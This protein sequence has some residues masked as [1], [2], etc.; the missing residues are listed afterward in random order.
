MKIYTKT[1]DDGS[2]SLGFGKRIPKCD[3]NIQSL[4]DLD[5]LNSNIGFLLSLIK[6]DSPQ[7]NNESFVNFLKKTQNIIFDMGTFIAYPKKT[8][9]VDNF[10]Q[11]ISEEISYMESEI[12]RLTEQLPALRAFIL[13]GGD[14]ITSY[15]HIV[16]SVCRRSERSLVA[17]QCSNEYILKFI[18][19]FSDYCF[20]LA[21]YVQW[22]YNPIDKEVIYMNWQ[23]RD[24]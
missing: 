11:F 12:D 15:L 16:R 24:S 14:K 19:R 9:D 13:P 20:T 10:N 3:F 5:E 22:K 18:N 8:G 2:T 21:R 7:Y 17:I 4:G 1:G 6:D 23:K